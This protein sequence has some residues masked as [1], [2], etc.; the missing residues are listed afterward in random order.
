MS[1]EELSKEIYD[2]R[3]RYCRML[4]HDLTFKYCRQTGEGLFCRRIF[5]CWYDKLEIARYIKTHFTE[6]EIQEV[7]RPG[8]PKLHTLLNLI[9]NS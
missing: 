3:E 2:S 6:R 5:D 8:A 1:S 7:L 4:G 9:D